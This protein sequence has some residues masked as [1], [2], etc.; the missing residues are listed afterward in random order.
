MLRAVASGSMFSGEGERGSGEKVN[1]R[2]RGR[3]RANGEIEGKLHKLL[4]LRSG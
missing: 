2:K 1:E 3:Q 4:N